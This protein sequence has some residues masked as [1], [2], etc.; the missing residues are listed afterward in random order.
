MNMKIFCLCLLLAITR[1]A[2][3]GGEYIGVFTT[4]ALMGRLL[5]NIIA[6]LDD[7]NPCYYD[8][9]YDPRDPQTWIP[10]D[11]ISYSS[12]GE[13]QL[14]WDDTNETPVE[15]EPQSPHPPKTGTLEV[16]DLSKD[17]CTK[18]YF[19]ITE[20]SPFWTQ[21]ELSKI[22][23]LFIQITECGPKCEPGSEGASHM[24]VFC[25]S[26]GLIPSGNCLHVG[27]GLNTLPKCL[28]RLTKRVLQSIGYDNQRCLVELVLV[29]NFKSRK[30][31][32]RGGWQVGWH[33]DAC[34][35]SSHETI[36]ILN[37]DS[38]GVPAHSFRLGI[39]NDGNADNIADETQVD[40]LETIPVLPGFGYA[41]NEDFKP[42]IFHSTTP[43]S[44]DFGLASRKCIIFRIA[45]EKAGHIQE[46]IQLYDNTGFPAD[47]LQ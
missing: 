47:T 40:T 9:T 36:I 12:T 46:T 3:A 19:V 26:P 33:R 31:D 45:G 34:A 38:S 20:A 41:V 16:K 21:K 30:Q 11:G 8:S 28:I 29:D 43:L 14:V 44:G 17:L 37:V 25:V 15:P 4:L 1:P 18:G 42:H 2:L 10:H 22:N 13:P 7:Q 27:A 24:S 35:G 39:R 32:S 5:S 23:N 6:L